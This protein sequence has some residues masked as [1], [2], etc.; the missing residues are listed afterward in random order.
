[1][2]EPASAVLLYAPDASHMPLRLQS[3]AG[4]LLPR[5]V[6]FSLPSPAGAGGAAG[7][8]FLLWSEGGGAGGGGGGG[9]AW[10]TRHIFLTFFSFFVLITS[11]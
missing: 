4:A 10:C 1:M 8:G 3:D 2:P 9:G 5:G 6:G 7:G 11:G